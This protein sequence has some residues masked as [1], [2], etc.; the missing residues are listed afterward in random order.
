M[1]KVCHQHVQEVQRLKHRTREEPTAQDIKQDTDVEFTE[2]MGKK[3][4][5]NT[6]LKAGQQHKKHSTQETN[7]KEATV[8][9]KSNATEHPSTLKKKNYPNSSKSSSKHTD[10]Q[11][12]QR[13]RSIEGNILYLVAYCKSSR[14]EGKS[15]KTLKVLQELN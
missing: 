1:Q 8:T 3:E 12:T 14:I 10:S 2:N 15:N 13:G 4:R 11:D 9:H 7:R 5:R 6:P